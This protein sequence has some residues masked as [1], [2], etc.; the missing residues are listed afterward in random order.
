MTAPTDTDKWNRI[1]ADN[2]RDS[3]QAA[4]VL[5]E[6]THLLPASGR[7]LDLACGLGANALLLAQHGFDTCAWD[8]SPTAIDKLQ[9]R[10]LALNIPL[11]AETRDVVALPPPADSFDVIVVSRFL[12]RT[13]IPQ[14][15]TAL[16]DGGLIY[17]QTF[18]KDKVGDSGPRN[19]DYRL[20]RNELL[21]LF[22][23][24][25]LIYF[26]EEGTLGDVRQGTR[27]EAMLIARR[28][29]TCSGQ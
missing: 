15:I 26:R 24:L 5:R 27:N 3:M 16:R 23:T 17:Y 25:Q 10:S 18:I 28:D 7:A 29:D 14:L 19:P 4:K 21:S 1:Y 9:S 8:I 22:R 11:Q 20:D 12:E 13:L 2:D 6:N